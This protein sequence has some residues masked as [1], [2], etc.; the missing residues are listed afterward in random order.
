MSLSQ[1]FTPTPK[2][3]RDRDHFEWHM[4]TGTLKHTIQKIRKNY[5]QMY[6]GGELEIFLTSLLHFP[7]FRKV[8]I[9]FEVQKK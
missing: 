2:Q 6:I 1:V 7:I 3:N 4:I 9:H 8:N 5:V